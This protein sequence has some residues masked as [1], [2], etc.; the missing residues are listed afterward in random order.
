LGVS[1]NG[2]A[3]GAVPLGVA[4]L[5]PAASAATDAVG[6]V[7]ADVEAFVGNAVAIIVES[8]ATHFRHRFAGH[9][10]THDIGAVCG[11]DERPA[12]GTRTDA[13]VA[14]VTGGIALVTL[15]VAIVVDAVATDFIDGR[16]W[17]G[18][19]RDGCP[20]FAALGDAAALASTNPVCARES[21]VEALVDEAVAIVVF[22]VRT[23]FLFGRRAGLCIA[24]DADA[25]LVA[26]RATA[27]TTDAFTRVADLIEVEALVD[28]HVAVVVGIVTALGVPGEILP[29]FVVTILADVYAISITVVLAVFESCTVNITRFG[30][31]GP[32]ACDL[33][34]AFIGRLTAVADPKAFVVIA[35]TVV[36]EAVAEFVLRLDGPNALTGPEA[37]DT[38]LD[39]RLA[40][41]SVDTTRS[42][43]AIIT[44]LDYG[45]I[46]L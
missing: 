9:D 11:A 24:G 18:I 2:A 14:D 44:V 33:L 29:I 32:Y 45:G 25:A 41:A 34:I 42:F 46:G 37:L 4:H 30:I 8:I 16:A 15:P 28:H 43:F 35:V 19:T 21:N 26:D 3:E 5:N 22:V 10:I 39:A 38:A 6:T 40:E 31:A 27:P 12:T 20:V 1:G 36:V 17:H 23:E 13:D 7:G